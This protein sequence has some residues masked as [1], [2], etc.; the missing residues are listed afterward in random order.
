[1]MGDTFFLQFSGLRYSYNPRNAIL[2]TVP[3]LDLPIPTTR[4]VINA[5][6]YTGEGR[7]GSDEDFYQPLDRGDEE[8]YCLVTDSYILSYLPMV[9]ELLPSLDIVLK[10]Q[11]GDPVAQDDLDKLVVKVDGQELKVWATVLEYAASQPTGD[12]GKPVVDPYYATTS[13]RINPTWTIP[14]LFWLLLGLAFI[15]V[16]I[17]LLVKRRKRYKA[18]I[19]GNLS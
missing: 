11:N 2:F 4:A 10:D 13:G 19:S 1:M 8:L 5:E 17:V 14:Y 16:L 7:Q 3:F 9:G 12:S 18:K 6:I 15:I